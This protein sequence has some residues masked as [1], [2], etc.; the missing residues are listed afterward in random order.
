MKFL[1]WR[2]MLLKTRLIFCLKLFTMFLFFGISS[3]VLTDI[4]QVE[5]QYNFQEKSLVLRGF[6]LE[7]ISSCVFEQ[8]ANKWPNLSKLSF[9]NNKLKTLP[10][11]VG[12]LQ[13]L[14]VIDLID[15]PFLRSLPETI[16]N[17]GK[18]KVLRLGNT[19]VANLPEQF[20]GLNN[21]EILSF[22]MTPIKEIPPFV[23]KLNK[24]RLL[25]ISR[26]AYI[27][28]EVFENLSL[29]G[30]AVIRDGEYDELVAKN[31]KLG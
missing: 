6:D 16:G 3:R 9:E 24:L 5:R 18:L 1:I 22:P 27:S 7:E 17:L 8:I 28:S 15:N 13:E 10:V 23:L 25:V 11:T 2:K 14:Q 12:L 29:R 31:G 4:T 20:G 26:D 30:V 19:V 21:L